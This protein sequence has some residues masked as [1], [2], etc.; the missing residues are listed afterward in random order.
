MGRA[1]Q[2]MRRLFAARRGSVYLEL[3]A[4]MI[5]MSG[6]FLGAA[7]VGSRTMDMDRS[8]R[9][10]RAGIDAIWSL[11]DQVAAPGQ[12]DFDAIGQRLVEIMSIGSGEA[13][14]IIFTMIEYDHAGPGLEIDWQGNYATTTS[15]SSRISI[16][17]PVA[18]VDGFDFWIRDDERM[19]VV[20]IYRSRQGLFPAGEL[21]FYTKGV[22]FKYDPDHL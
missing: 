20:E 12:S 13:F 6:I 10:I 11:D 16:T 9:A 21:V 15:K 7:V 14:N 18:N 5:L 2:H 8:G 17:P 1:A 22:V 4:V 19:V 3:A